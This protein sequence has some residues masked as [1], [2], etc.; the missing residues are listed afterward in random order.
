MA[1]ILKVHIELEVPDYINE[2][3][4]GSYFDT[5]D[6]KLN[7]YLDS[8]FKD[9]EDMVKTKSSICFTV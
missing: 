3:Q 8:E 2:N 5:I 1:K 6:E 4:V 7:E 9:G